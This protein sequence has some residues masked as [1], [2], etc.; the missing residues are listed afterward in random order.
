MLAAVHRRKW[1]PKSPFLVKSYKTLSIL[2]KFR[3]FLDK[4]G[5]ILT[6]IADFRQIGPNLTILAKISPNSAGFQRLSPKIL[7]I[8][9]S[10]RSDWNRSI[11]AVKFRSFCGNFR[12]NFFAKN[13]RRRSSLRTPCFPVWVSINIPNTYNGGRPV[14]PGT[15]IQ[16]IMLLEYNDGPVLAQISYIVLIEYTDGPDLAQSFSR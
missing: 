6:E 4:F 12:D 9:G 1:L 10:A 8:F 3:K 15:K 11:R 2:V 14:L 16:A 13:A 5:N 7:P